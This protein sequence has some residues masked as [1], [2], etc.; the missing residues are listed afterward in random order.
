MK[1]EVDYMKYSKKKRGTILSQFPDPD[2]QLPAE[3]V[4]KV[5]ISA[6]SEDIEVPDVSG[7]KA[8]HAKKYLEALGFEVD[9]VKVTGSKVNRGYVEKSSPEAGSVG[10][11]GDVIT[12]RVSTQD[13]T[14]TTKT[15][16]TTQTKSTTSTTEETVPIWDPTKTD[17]T[18]STTSSTTSSGGT[19]SPSRRED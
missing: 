6:G 3:S 11:E 5:V 10:K 19:T 15:T 14:T 1:V 8:A 4:I 2:T 17:P 12:L 9:T 13:T 16:T 18:T 7:W